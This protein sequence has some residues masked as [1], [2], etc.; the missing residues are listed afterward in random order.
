[1][2]TQILRSMERD[3]LVQRTVY[4]EVPPRVEY[5]L[6]PLGQTLRMP[7]AALRDWAEQ[8]VGFII[9]AQ[10]KYDNRVAVTAQTP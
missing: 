6:T 2:L 7:L 1:M 9:D 5:Q 10:E 8:N 3:G 4:A